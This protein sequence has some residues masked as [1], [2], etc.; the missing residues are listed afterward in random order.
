L[1]CGALGKVSIV[2]EPLRDFVVQ[3]QLL[4]G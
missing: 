3:W 1:A 2:R 4:V